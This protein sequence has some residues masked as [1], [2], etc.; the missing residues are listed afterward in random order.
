MISTRTFRLFLSS[1]FS[2]FLAEREAL[3]RDVF[4]RL[5]TYCAER[6]SRFQVWREDS[7]K[8][9]PLVWITSRRD[10]PSAEFWDFTDS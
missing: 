6:G 4:P 3:Q 5:E 2:D 9:V 8:K 7:C 10:A 1:T